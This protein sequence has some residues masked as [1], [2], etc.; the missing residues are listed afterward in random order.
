MPN[1]DFKVDCTVLL[2]LCCCWSVMRGDT[3][4]FIDL[5]KSQQKAP[6]VDN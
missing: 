5:I 2:H 4:E 3:D 6:D 1:N